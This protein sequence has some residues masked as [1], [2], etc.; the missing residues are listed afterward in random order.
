[1]TNKKNTNPLR[2]PYLTLPGAVGGPD[3]SK[4]IASMPKE[5]EHRFESAGEFI[6]R[7]AAR[8]SRW[9]DGLPDHLEPVILALLS[10][11]DMIEVLSIGEDGHSSVV[12]EGLADGAPCMLITHQASFQTLCYTRE[13][14]ESDDDETT[15]RRMI[16]FH[17]GGEQIDV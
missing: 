4:I 17:V 9:R 16:G 2:A 11:G 1:M 7:L 15:P 3:L 10:T 13:V 5:Q 8:I 12:V 14:E 6:K